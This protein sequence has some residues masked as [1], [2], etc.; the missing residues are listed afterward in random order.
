MLLGRALVDGVVADGQTKGQSNLDSDSTEAHLKHTSLID[1]FR[2]R[3]RFQTN[4]SNK[5]LIPLPRSKS[6]LLFQ[7]DL[8]WW[9][10]KKR[11]FL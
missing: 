3:T 8:V 5:T 11:D 9:W 1:E 4:T 6:S 7:T 10:K 2:T